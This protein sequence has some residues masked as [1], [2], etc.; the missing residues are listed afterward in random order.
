VCR[1][2]DLPPSM[3]SAWELHESPI[4]MD[5]WDSLA[6][7]YETGLGELAAERSAAAEV[8]RADL[9]ARI[10]PEGI[11]FHALTRHG[12]G[13]RENR[14]TDV[15]E[16]IAARLVHRESRV[17]INRDGVRRAIELIVP[18]PEATPAEPPMTAEELKAL[19]LRKGAIG[20]RRLADAI[21]SVCGY[22]ISRT[23]IAKH[24]NGIEPIPSARAH[25][26]RRALDTLPDV[27]GPPY[28]RTSD[29]ELDAAILAAVAA[30][31]GRSAS[32][33]LEAVP[34]EIKRRWARL[35]L[36]QETECIR[37][38]SATAAPDTLSRRYQRELLYPR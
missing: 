9:I 6:A 35:R 23:M 29:D 33:V 28:R 3:L 18:G 30:T 22:E 36:L 12:R 27:S 21:R 26:Y 5:C 31:P 24:R 32:Q 7:L 4:P 17:T 15:D 38:E 37:T 8:R 10:P 16:L 19:M 34:G 1:L 13:T 2:L 25:D 14:E 11:S 20:T